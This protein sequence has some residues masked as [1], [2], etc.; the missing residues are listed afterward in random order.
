MVEWTV[1]SLVTAIRNAGPPLYAAALIST[2]LLLLLPD[3]IIAELALLQFRQA[4]RLELGVAFIA[5]ASLLIVQGLFALAPF[6]RTQWQMWRRRRDARE[7]L[8][9]LTKAEKEFLRTFIIGGENTRFESLYDGVANGLIAKHILY[10]A[11]Q[12]TVPGMPGML[13]AYNLQPYFRKMLNKNRH[14]LDC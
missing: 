5:S 14:F 9:A 4:H 1:G 13:L 10:R 8:A 11:S 12:L 3:Y 6:L 2:L 7:T